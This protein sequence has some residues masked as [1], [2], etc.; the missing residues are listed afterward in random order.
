MLSPAGHE[1]KAVE[2][3]NR[4]SDLVRNADNQSPGKYPYSQR[5]IWIKGDGFIFEK[6]IKGDGFIFEK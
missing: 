4:L 5:D 6:W 1:Q 2:V 3:S